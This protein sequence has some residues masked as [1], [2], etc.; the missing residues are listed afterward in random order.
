MDRFDPAVFSARGLVAIGYAAF[1]FA[2][3]VASGALTRRTLPA[4]ATTLLGFTATRIAFTVGV[5]P[6]LLAARHLL[7]PLG[8]GVGFVGTPSSIGV[9]ASAPEIR[10][11][12]AT[13]ASLV[14]HGGHVLSAGQLHDLLVRTCP[15]I[16]AGLPANPGAGVTKGPAGLAGGA[17]QSCLQG[18]SSHL[19]LLV[20]YQPPSHYWPL[21]ALETAI[22]LAVAVALIGVTLWRLQRRAI[23]RPAAVGRTVPPHALEVA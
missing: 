1:A 18:L 14:D 6:H 20:G 19:Q 7:L 17:F 22:F 4:M 16:A 10:N 15:T 2:F 3:G 12:W 11:G 5:R 9:V 21:Q 13:S 23:R 8:Q